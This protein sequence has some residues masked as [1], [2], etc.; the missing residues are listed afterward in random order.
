MPAGQKYT[1]PDE[2]VPDRRLHTA[3]A[4]VVGAGPAG[5]TNSPPILTDCAGWL[6]SLADKTAGGRKSP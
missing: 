6:V 3:A 5:D 1:V 2:D 4:A